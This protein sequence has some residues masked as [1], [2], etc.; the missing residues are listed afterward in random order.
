MP[1]PPLPKEVLQEIIHHASPSGGAFLV[2]GQA[3]NFWADRYSGAAPEL[4]SYGPYTSKDVDFFGT[5][6]AA[7]KLATSLGGGVRVPRPR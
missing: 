7:R 2:G 1:A 5:V 6:D 3:L 4:D